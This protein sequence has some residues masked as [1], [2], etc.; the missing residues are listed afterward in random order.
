MIQATPAKSLSE[1]RR[2][3]P[4]NTRQTTHAFLWPQTFQAILDTGQFTC[5]DLSLFSSVYIQAFL[6]SGSSPPCVQAARG[7]R[8][9]I[10]PNR[11]LSGHRTFPF[12]SN[13]GFRQRHRRLQ[14]L[15]RPQPGNSFVPISCP[16][17]ALVIAF[18]QSW[19][20]LLST[21]SSLLPYPVLWTWVQN[22]HLPYVMRPHSGKHFI[23]ALYNANMLT[24]ST[25]S[26]GSLIPP[27]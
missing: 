20:L 26:G 27:C 11:R 19:P 18:H 22:H 21:T 3:E 1:Y 17:V 10:H 24:E 9:S 12:R 2:H 8:P 7:Y 13:M 15:H 23:I 16:C 5:H 6:I 14:W 25:Y 4:L